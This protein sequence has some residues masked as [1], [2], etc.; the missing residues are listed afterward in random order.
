VTCH[1]LPTGAGTDYTLNLQTQQYSQLP[2][3]TS[4]QR[5]LQMVSVDGSTNISI[6]T[7]QIRNAYFKIGFECTQTE[8]LA[9]FGFLHDGSV[10]SIARFVGEP[11]FNVQ[12]DQEVADLVAFIM[13]MSG[14]DLPQGAVNTPFSPPG[15]ASKDSPAA[16]G[17]QT[18]L[19]SV[20]SAPAAQLQLIQTMIT[21]AQNGKIGLI[22]KGRVG[23]EPRG[24]VYQAVTQ[25]FQSDRA[26]QVF[27]PAALQALAVLGGE[28]TYT[29]V[30]TGTQT[31]LGIDRD[32]DGV[33]D[34]DQQDL[35]CYANCDGSHVSPILN[36]LDFNCFL[37]R[38]SAGD[39]YANCDG[40][41]VAPV[42][43]VLDFNCFLNRFSAG[44][45]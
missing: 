26:G 4:G 44:C 21:L 37:N 18:T 39:P 13:C 43:N 25:N 5:H 27:T 9:G 20:Q 42:L 32:E 19:V 38:F 16:V 31:R 28:L 8:S 15:P 12:S 40:S 22:V 23:G 34:R 45:P 10:D 33:L 11:V 24:F 2:A 41:T 30:Q 7:P 14:S 36:V 17:A 3:G 35:N 1:T 29:A 6:K